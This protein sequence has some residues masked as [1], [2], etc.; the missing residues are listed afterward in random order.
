M[1]FFLHVILKFSRAHVPLTYVDRWSVVTWYMYSIYIGTG[2]SPA[3]SPKPLSCS[4]P[5]N[6]IL[7]RGGVQVLGHQ[8]PPLLNFS[9]APVPLTLF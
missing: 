2:P 8:Q 3:P 1:V 4:C 9:L 7:T 6:P 5:F